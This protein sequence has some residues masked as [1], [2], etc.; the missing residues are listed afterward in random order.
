MDAKE[1]RIGNY[2]YSRGWVIKSYGV[3]GFI[4]IIKNISNYTP[5]PLTKEW[6]VKFGF[7]CHW[8]EDYDNHV[9]SLIRSGNYDDVII[10]PSWVSQTECN[11]FV[12]AHFDYEMD[13]EIKH[14]HQLQNLYFALTNKELNIKQIEYGINRKV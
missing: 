8:D 1:L 9:F 5:I 2:V 13:L 6:L 4:N 3:D 11:R 14:V 7:T 12:I 10:D